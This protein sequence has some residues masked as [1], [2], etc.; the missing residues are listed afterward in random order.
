LQYKL[1]KEGL[2]YSLKLLELTEALIKGDKVKVIQ[3][4]NR[5]KNF[6]YS[7]GKILN[8]KDKWDKLE[9]QIEHYLEQSNPSKEDLL[10]IIFQITMMDS[11]I[12]ENSGA[13]A[14][15][16]RAAINLIIAHY[17]SFPPILFAYI[18]KNKIPFFL[19]SVY[20]EHYHYA[21][22]FKKDLGKVLPIA[23]FEKETNFFEILKLDKLALSWVKDYTFE[24]E[25][26]TKLLLIFTLF[27]FLSGQILII[28][29]VFSILKGFSR[30][31]K[32]IEELA[33]S[34]KAGTFH[35][36]KSKNL[37][38]HEE[39]EC[40]KSLKNLISA[41][42][43]QKNVVIKLK[44]FLE[45]LNRGEFKEITKEEFTGIWKDIFKELR[46]LMYQLA[47]LKEIL[48]KYSILINTGEF[49]NLIEISKL[50][51]PW[52][53][54]FFPLQN[55]IKKLDE[56]AEG[57]GITLWHF[58]QG[59]FEIRLP[60]VMELRGR[61]EEIYESF[62]DLKNNLD[63]IL[64]E[65]NRVTEEIVSG[66]LMVNIQIKSFEGEFQSLL[67][68]L[69]KIIQKMRKQMESIR[70]LWE[71]EEELLLF[72]QTI[73]EDK[74]IETVYNR[75]KELL[76][77]KF[78]FNTFAFYEINSSQNYI[79]KR[80]VY[81]ESANFC[82]K[83]VFTN[84]DLCRCKKI[85]Q[86]VWGEDEK[87]GKVCPMFLPKKKYYLCYPFVFEEGVKFI[88]QVVCD[89]KEKFYEVR[90]KLPKIKRYIENIIPL[91]TIKELMIKHKIEK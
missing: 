60:K 33:D 86:P 56:F 52:Q 65:M 70:Y 37:L 5:L 8:I 10:N 45:A 19:V 81:P 39:N 91:I 34:I 85:G 78:G 90:R 49:Y 53:G 11:I 40:E 58:S 88:L 12:F 79:I 82:N 67:I 23:F 63:R 87:W 36:V 61:Y 77:N 50:S 75:I 74:D 26:S 14:D 64:F 80:V 51:K 57:I 69:D 41:I 15:P 4:A 43:I 84:A 48:I 25:H 35:N 32:V 89:S 55:A 29:L 83:E 18:K 47:E 6:S 30:R 21:F 72:K 46:L 73:E 24:R 27:I 7:V 76:K 2:C 59:V 17:L 3:V 13:I 28:W 16:D 62:K 71:E 20:L 9:V 22:M 66:N 38:W 1:E 31:I 42:E 68:M 54:M 44:L